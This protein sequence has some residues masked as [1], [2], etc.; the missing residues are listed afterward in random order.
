MVV[1]V[2]VRLRVPLNFLPFIPVSYRLLLFLGKVPHTVR[3]EE[4]P[5]L[6]FFNV[7]YR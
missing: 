4:G 7:Y 5:N 2:R 6:P 1:P 3:F